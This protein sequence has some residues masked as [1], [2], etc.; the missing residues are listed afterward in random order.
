[1]KKNYRILRL[2]PKLILA[3]NAAVL[4]FGIIGGTLS[5]VTSV[6]RL[7]GSDMAAPCYYQYFTK[8]R[9]LKCFV[10]EESCFQV[11]HSL[12]TT[13]DLLAAVVHSEI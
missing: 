6:I 3:L 12:A 9:F 11:Y 4:I 5:T 2:T 10:T 1:M 7:V 8:G 13:V